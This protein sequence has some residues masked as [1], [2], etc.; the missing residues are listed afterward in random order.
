MHVLELQKQL[1]LLKRE[2]KAYAEAPALLKSDNDV[3]L[4]LIIPVEDKEIVR[5]Q[6]W[7]SS[8][9]VDVLIELGFKDT[10]P[11]MFMTT[12]YSPDC[13]LGPWVFDNLENK[14][15]DGITG[16][17]YERRLLFDRIN[18]A[19]MEI[20][21]SFMD[22]CPWVR[23]ATVGFGLKWRKCEVRDELHKLLAV[24]EKEAND[25][26]SGKLL[27]KEMHWLDS[28]DS[29]DM[30]GTEIEKLLI[31]D[32]ITELVTMNSFQSRT[33]EVIGSYIDR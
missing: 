29:I 6:C 31:N 24:Q 32:L 18:S 9:I 12:W 7:E 19:L 30:I 26:I 20:S 27:D 22:L 28:R 21:E 17:K 8:Y 2:S 13:P 33:G 5:S 1:Q 25:D 23:P 4:G 10:D 3:G 16:L 11:N 14:Y 15:Y